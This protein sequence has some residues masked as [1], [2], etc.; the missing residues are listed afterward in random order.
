MF[1]LNAVPKPSFNRNSLK[2]G[3]YTRFSPK[4]R[5]AIIDRD[6][7]LCVRCMRPYHS[8]HHVQFASDLGAGTEDNGVLCCLDCHNFA[9]AGRKGREWFEWYK[10]TVLIPH[11]KGDKP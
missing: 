8:I 4:T 1:S 5:R 7:G 9:H 2:R 6:G 3:K 11:Y 10:Q